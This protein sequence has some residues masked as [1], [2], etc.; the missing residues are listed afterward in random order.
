MSGKSPFSTI[1][2]PASFGNAPPM[3]SMAA[4][5]S[6]GHLLAGLREPQPG[7]DET[8]HPDVA[9]SHAGDEDG[10]EDAY[11]HVP[12]SEV[13]A[14]KIRTLDHCRAPPSQP[15]PGR[16]SRGMSWSILSRT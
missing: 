4:P 16:R 3:T 14:K 7:A 12:R 9:P 1:P 10:V 6:V 2:R 11:P 5:S 8:A 15:N 13:D